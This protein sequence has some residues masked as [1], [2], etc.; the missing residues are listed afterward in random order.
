MVE[1][2][3]IVVGAGVAGLASA[4]ALSRAGHNVQV[5]T[6]LIRNYSELYLYQLITDEVSDS[7]EI[8]I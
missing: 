2:D 8:G 6:V 3:I 1:L 5:R 4:I 7:G